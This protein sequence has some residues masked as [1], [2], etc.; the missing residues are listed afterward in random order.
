MKYIIYI[1]A[2][3]M[4]VL[5]CTQLK[6]A[7]EHYSNNEY[8]ETIAVC[9]D[10]LVTDSTNVDALAL[11]ADAYEQLD[12]LD[13]ALLYYEQASR[14]AAEPKQ[15]D[16]QRY[17]I[18]I[19]QGNDVVETDKD[20]ALRYYDRAINLYPD[21]ARALEKKADVFYSMQKYEQAKPLY[22]SAYETTWDSTRVRSK[23]AK[24]DSI[25]A[26]TQERIK[27]GRRLIE[28]KEY[29]AAKRVLNKAVE[30][31]PKSDEARYQLHIAT[32]LR[33]YQRGSK[34][35][36]WEAIE[37]FGFASYIFPDRGE[38]HYYMGLAYQKKDKEEYS[39]AIESLKRAVRIDPDGEFA[40]KAKQEAERIQA[41]KEKMDAFW[42]R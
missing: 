14:V 37:E 11:M 38:P 42:G 31:K 7:Q 13:S 21:R 5:S 23:I 6:V 30:T 41:R 12:K 26:V 15:F 10:I 39:N 36:L 1:C 3:L 17:Q 20:A 34:N 24:I 27:Q 4:L 19:R 29:D 18:L 33:L 9:R 32:G 22:A 25:N 35:A 2:G 8:E 16:N 28:N 40:E